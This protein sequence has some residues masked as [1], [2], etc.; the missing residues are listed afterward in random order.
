MKR[1]E[2]DQALRLFDVSGTPPVLRTLPR[3]AVAR[4]EALPGPAFDH[5]R[6]G[7]SRQELLD[8]AAFLKAGLPAR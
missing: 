6:L 7:Y 1:D 3:D 5:G 4:V 8:L 2:S